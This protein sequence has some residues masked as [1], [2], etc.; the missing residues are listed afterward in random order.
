MLDAKPNDPVTTAQVADLLRQAEL[1]EPALELY[2]KAAASPPPTPSIR[3]ISANTSITSNGPTKPRPRGPRSPTAQTETR[4]TLAR[5]S[6]VLAGFG[7]VKEALPKLG[8]AVS[9]E[10]DSFDLRLK[11]ASL[12]HRLEKYDDAETQLAAADKLAEKDEEKDAVLDARVKNDQAANR[13][14]RRIEVCVKSS[15]P[16]AI[17][18]TGLDRAGPLSRGRWQAARG[19][20]RR[21][22]GRRDRSAS[23]GPGRWP[24]VARVGRQPG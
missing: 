23:I 21:R 14:A 9:L 18:G 16:R 20:P 5:L 1:T 8:E 7:Y 2:R 11:L 17:H 3:N 6:E 24:P 22:E 12:N 4:K 15:K 10:P 19:R 13:L